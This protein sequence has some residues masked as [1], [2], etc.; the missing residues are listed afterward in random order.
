LSGKT[1]A[2]LD[3][4]DLSPQLSDWAR[5]PAAQRS[6]TGELLKTGQVTID[7]LRDFVHPIKGFDGRLVAIGQPL[8]Y[9][10]AFHFRAY[11]I[12]G[13]PSSSE[14]VSSVLSLLSS[15]YDVVLIDLGRSWGVSTFAALPWCERVLFVVDDDGMSVRRSL[16]ALGRLKH[17]SGDPEE[18]NLNK[19]VVAF[20]KMTGR[21]L[22]ERDIRTAVASAE[23]FPTGVPIAPV[24][25]TEK[26]RQWGAE[27]TTL[28]TL[29]EPRVRASLDRLAQTLIPGFLADGSG[30]R[31]KRQESERFSFF[32]LR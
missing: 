8:L 3:F 18:F 29:C 24:L 19:W 23:L 10:E 4:D 1:V 15:E 13:A 22:S 6:L 2:L 5:I 27:G 11:V 7:R 16:D 17:E 30:L 32:S 20:N 21:R 25:Y 31:P 14:F 26:G 28:Y 12:E 9:S